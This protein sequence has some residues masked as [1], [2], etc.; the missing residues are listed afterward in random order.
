MIEV[1]LETR[2]SVLICG[3]PKRSRVGGG[4]VD[5]VNTTAVHHDAEIVAADAQ[6]ATLALRALQDV[7]W[8]DLTP[9]ARG[10]T[11]ARMRPSGTS[12]ALAK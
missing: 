3:W 12:L 10:P 7:E 9:L 2:Q 11:V 6:V 1:T 8:I 4:E 5:S